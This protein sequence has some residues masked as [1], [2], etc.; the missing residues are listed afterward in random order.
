MLHTS[1]LRVMLICIQLILTLAFAAAV[2]G[3]C[4]HAATLHLII[5]CSFTSIHVTMCSYL[6]HAV[7]M[8]HH[9][10]LYFVL[11]TVVVLVVH[12]TA[13]HVLVAPPIYSLCVALLRVIQLV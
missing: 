6:L 10:V 1:S 9:V 3:W 8:H 4:I 7:S 11:H 13:D 5:I 2:G 12:T